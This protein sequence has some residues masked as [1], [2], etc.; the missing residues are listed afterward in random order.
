MKSGTA[1]VLLNMIIIINCAIWPKERT[2][3]YQIRR[4]LG[5]KLIKNTDGILAKNNYPYNL[6]TSMTY[7]TYFTIYCNYYLLCT[8][9]YHVHVVHVVTWKSI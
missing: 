9:M 6:Y 5:Y 8:Y 7:T 2:V 4:C 3:Q 1:M